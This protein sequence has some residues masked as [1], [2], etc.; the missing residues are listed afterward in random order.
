MSD[1]PEA[2]PKLTLT[3]EQ[4]RVLGRVYQFLIETGQKRV[5]RLAQEKQ[6][7]GKADQVETTE[8]RSAANQ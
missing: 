3:A 2:T 6:P 7:V 8:I 4:K 5:Q 1:N